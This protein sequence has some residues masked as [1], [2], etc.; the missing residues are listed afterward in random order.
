[1]ARRSVTPGKLGGYRR[2]WGLMRSEDDGVNFVL[3]KL[4]GGLVVSTINGLVLEAQVLGLLDIAC[5]AGTL[6]D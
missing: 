4:G 5:G 2:F 1:M 3:I 6:G